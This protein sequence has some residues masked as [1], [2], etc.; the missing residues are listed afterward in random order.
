MLV[1]VVVVIPE[2]CQ[3][4]LRREIRKNLVKK[5]LIET[6]LLEILDLNDNWPASQ[7]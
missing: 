1:R 2:I 4:S 7:I 6:S 3:Q 5:A